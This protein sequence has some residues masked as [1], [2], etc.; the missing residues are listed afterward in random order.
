M[1]LLVDIFFVAFSFMLICYFLFF[2]GGLPY[3]LMTVNPLMK[4]RTSDA[5]MNH[6]KIKISFYQIFKFILCV[7][8]VMC[9][10]WNDGLLFYLPKLSHCCTLMEVL[11]SQF[12]WKMST[13]AIRRVIE[14]T[15]A[16][17]ET[18]CGKILARKLFFSPQTVTAMVTYSAANFPVFMLLSISEQVIK[19]CCCCVFEYNFSKMWSILF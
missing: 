12:K 6:E 18:F 4:L 11:S 7:I 2:Q 17:W 14:T 3:W 8:Q 13:E 9:T 19:Y 1:V 5:S 16:D 10:M 15:L